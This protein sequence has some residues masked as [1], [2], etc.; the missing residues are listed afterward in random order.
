MKYRITYVTSSNTTMDVTVEA[1]THTQ[2][3]K[4]AAEPHRLRQAG[5]MKSLAWEIFFLSLRT[6]TPAVRLEITKLCRL[7]IRKCY[8]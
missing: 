5:R 7:L 6:Q 2:A 4:A 3:M 8:E 1:G